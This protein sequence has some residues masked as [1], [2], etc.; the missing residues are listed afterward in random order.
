MTRNSRNFTPAEKELTPLLEDTAALRKRDKKAEIKKLIQAEE[1]VA[2]DLKKVCTADIAAVEESIV[3]VVADV[4]MAAA[5]IEIEILVEKETP[6]TSNL[7]KTRVV[8]IAKTN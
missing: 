3:K 5:D 6:L 8:N 1:E 7:K 2:P 4:E